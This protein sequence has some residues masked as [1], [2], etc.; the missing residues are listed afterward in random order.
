MIRPL[1]SVVLPVYNAEQTVAAAVRSIRAQTLEDWELIVVDD[2]STDGSL[3][4]IEKFAD[5][6]IRLMRNGGN[7]GLAAS[8][9]RG[10]TEAA[11]KYFARM[12]ADDVSFPERLARQLAYLEAHPTVDL[13]GAGMMV[14]TRDDQPLGVLHPPASHGE[15]CAAGRRGL[16]PLYHPTWF[17]RAEWHRTHPYD[18]VYRKAQ[19]FELLL[20]AA[21]TSTY[22]NLSE[23]L[24]AYRSE[25]AQMRK[26]LRT[27][28]YV[29]RALL[30][31]L[32]GAGWSQ[33]VRGMCLTGLKGFGDVVLASPTGRLLRGSLPP[34]DPVET[35]TWA[36]VRADSKT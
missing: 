27:R 28:A 4:Q 11:G 18:P 5:P 6:R 9:N 15:I 10:H 34:P 21:S 36:K 31:H 25:A 14:V 1:I 35:S 26:R 17:A 3:A 13:V 24:L 22:A 33:R 7:L 16:F 29:V 32:P 12:D 8:L 2:A 30:R 23:V 20:R 19:D